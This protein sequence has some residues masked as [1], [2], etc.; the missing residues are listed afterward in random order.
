MS[1]K[2][3]RAF[4]LVELLVVIAIIALLT[5]VLLPTVGRARRSAQAAGCAANLRGWATAVAMY[6]TDNAGRYWVDFGNYPPPGSGQG[7][8]MRVLSS[9]YENL[10]RFRLCP[11][12][13]EPGGSWGSRT[14]EAWGP[15]PASAGFL[16][17]PKDYGSYGIN[18]WINDLPKTGPFRTG[19]RKRPELQWRRLGATGNPSNSPLIGDCEWYGG[20]PLDLASGSPSGAVPTVENALFK[21]VH[22]MPASWNY[23]LARFA[24][25]RHRRG[26]NIAFEDGSVRHVEKEELWRLTWY[27]GFRPATVKLPF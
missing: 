8:W 11:S 9:Y 1:R 26:I 17:D 5:A 15:I 7:T 22:G 4:T 18:H 21:Q 24:M 25:N 13:T 23:D 20:I 27:K 6:T 16:F 2:F 10:D 19:W 12:S 3:V 14:F